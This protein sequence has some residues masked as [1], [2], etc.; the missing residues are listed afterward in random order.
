MDEMDSF[1]K[2]PVASA[3]LRRSTARRAKAM[4]LVVLVVTFALCA[5]LK[6]VLERLQRKR[7]FPPGTRLPP[8]PPR[9]SIRGHEELNL[10]NFHFAKG[11]EWAKEYGPVYRLN[12]NFSDVVVLSNARSI[13]NFC[14]NTD[15]LYRSGCFVVGRDYCKGLAT[16]N[17]NFWAAN[18]KYCMSTLRDLGFAQ[19]SMEER[20]M[21]HFRKL[22]LKIG[23]TK[24]E[25]VFIRPYLLTCLVSNI[26]SFVYSS[27]LPGGMAAL[28]TVTSILERMQT[29]MSGGAVIQYLPSF[30]RYLLYYIPFTR[31]GKVQSIMDEMDSFVNDQI[32]TYVPNPRVADG[33]DFIEGYVKKMAERK[34]DPYS[35]FQGRFLVGNVK[36]FLIAGTFST[37]NTMNWH[38]VNFAAR[39][40]VQAR[41]QNE[42][43][44]V[45]GP[46]RAP[47]WEDRRKM[48]YTLACAWEI[49][50]WKPAPPLGMPREANEDIVVDEFV[51]PKGTVVLFNFWAAHYDT[52]IW[53]E[54]K[55]FNPDRFLDKDGTFLPEKLENLVPFSVGEL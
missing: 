35:T 17:G 28:E 21:E 24:G 13:K 20:M 30:F 40:E 27:G 50:R 16:M 34:E 25:P 53:T 7:S 32:Q 8:M 33:R 42:I 44:E 4:S 19:T 1:V 37:T 36:T 11:M 29:I 10:K 54:P 9:S 39:P 3:A 14:K 22:E 41:V 51:I 52:E 15:G 26:I 38:L 48:P 45:V 2:L 18:K 31:N 5:L 23:E 46:E 49:H 43:D 6:L 47:T 12:L 55:R